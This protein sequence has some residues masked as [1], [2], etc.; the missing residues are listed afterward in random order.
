MGGTHVGKKGKMEAWARSLRVDMG[1]LMEGLRTE[2]ERGAAQH[3]AG[4]HPRVFQQQNV[5]CYVHI[6]M[7]T[8]VRKL[9]QARG[10]RSWKE[11]RT[12]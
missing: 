10:K 7:L 11:E 3:E 4:T 6:H 5:N 9:T 12:L 2:G 8:G 1:F